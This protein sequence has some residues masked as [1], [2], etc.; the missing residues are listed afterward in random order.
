MNID[1]I[2]RVKKAM[3]GVDGESAQNML[4]ALLL[5]AYHLGVSNGDCGDKEGSALDAAAAK[6]FVEGTRNV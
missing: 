1:D 6:I 5:D 4:L 2:K 3:T